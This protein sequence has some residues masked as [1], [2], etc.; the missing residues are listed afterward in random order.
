MDDPTEPPSAD[1]LTSENRAAS[2]RSSRRPHP[3]PGHPLLH[4]HRQPTVNMPIQRDTARAILIGPD[5]RVLLF[6]H[7]HP[8][9]WEREGWLTPGGAIDPGESPAEAVVREL[10]EETGHMLDP[11]TV[12]AAIAADAGEWSQNG[13]VF[14]TVNWYFFARTATSHIDLSGQGD[15]ERRDLLDHRWW[16]PAEVQACQVREQQVQQTD[17]PAGEL[18]QHN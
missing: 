13:T 12:G 10:R 8:E 4:Q 15:H 14:A 9:P 11:S 1:S 5:D 16:T 6:Q 2:R 17:F 18:V 7:H 3:T